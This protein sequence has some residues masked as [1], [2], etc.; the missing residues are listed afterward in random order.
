MTAERIRLNVFVKGA[1]ATGRAVVVPAHATVAELLA[2]CAEK[3][4]VPRVIRLLTTATDKAELSPPT[5]DIATLGIKH[6]TVLHAEIDAS[7]QPAVAPS[8]PAPA[9]APAPPATTAPPAP[10][11]AK[12]QSESTRDGFGMSATL[13]AVVGPAGTG[14]AYTLHVSLDTPPPK[15]RKTLLVVL[16]DASGSML[17]SWHQVQQALLYI[18]GESIGG[19]TEDSGEP[20]AS[21]SSLAVELVVYATTA[22]R[23]VFT[24]ENY[25]EVIMAERARGSTCFASAF[26]ACRE[27]VADHARRTRAMDVIVALMTDGGHTTPRNAFQAYSQLKEYLASLTESSVV[28][29]CIGFT[30]HHKF[31]TLDRIRRELGK[32]EGSFQYAEPSD[33]RTALRRKMEGVF[34]VASLFGGR[35][36]ADF[37]ISEFA[38]DRSGVQSSTLTTP[39]VIDREGKAALSFKVQCANPAIV[40]PSEDMFCSLSC[41]L[42]TE[43]GTG[44]VELACQCAVTVTRGEVAAVLLEMRAITDATDELFERISHL[45]GAPPMEES[46]R[47]NR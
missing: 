7:E 11:T 4:G 28:V 17:P 15:E 33:G 38:F 20:S 8:A 43:R 21:P 13:D 24:R 14:A 35:L 10:P 25:E 40:A 22:K 46:V 29:H 12:P 16:A 23:L 3:L 18:A 6:D 41:S 26:D 31:E 44:V 36:V 9:P 27:I 37:A 39:V 32:V 5:A 2:K 34:D 1:E 19:G 42:K 30:E 45:T 47:L